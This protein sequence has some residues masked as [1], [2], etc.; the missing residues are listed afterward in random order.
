MA[1]ETFLQSLRNHWLVYEVMNWDLY[2]LPPT[3]AEDHEQALKH[4]GCETRLYKW[5]QS[6]F[7]GCRPPVCHCWS[8]CCTVYIFWQEQTRAAIQIP[9]QMQSSRSQT[10]QSSLVHRAAAPCFKV[11]GTRAVQEGLHEV[12]KPKQVHITIMTEHQTVSCR[13]KVNKVQMNNLKGSRRLTALKTKGKVS[14]SPVTVSGFSTTC[15]GSCGS[16]HSNIKGAADHSSSKYR[17]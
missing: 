9:S 10:R 5:K 17:N 7:K 4:K 16:D 2:F 11:W 14:R 8:I 1:T 12:T 15:G 13:M 3:C 6:Y